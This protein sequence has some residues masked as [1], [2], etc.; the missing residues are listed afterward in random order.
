MFLWGKINP[1]FVFVDT[2]GNKLHNVLLMVG[3]TDF[4]N[5]EIFLFLYA[6]NV[7]KR[8]LSYSCVSQHRLAQINDF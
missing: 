2:F 4:Y 6:Q 7:S 8:S 5:W 3:D 1:S